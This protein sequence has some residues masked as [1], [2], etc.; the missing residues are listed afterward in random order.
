MSPHHADAVIDRLIAPDMFTGFGIRT[1]SAQAGAYNP[2]SYHNG[3]VW[4]HDTVLAAAG[5]AAYGRRDAAATVIGGLLDALEA[6]GG[7]LPELFC[8]FSRTDKPVPVTYPASCSPQAWAAATPFEL[9]RIAV[10]LDLDL[11]RGI[12]RVAAT[13]A[14]VGS[15]HIERLPAGSARLHVAADPVHAELR[16]LS[17][18]FAVAH[19]SG[20]ASPDGP[21]VATDD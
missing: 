14:V 11:P 5:M 16:G 4:P 10:G 21:A 19:A 17:G 2:V 3:S 9:L 12:A 8:G 7:R 13:P 6:H 1:L 15:V 18:D 20:D